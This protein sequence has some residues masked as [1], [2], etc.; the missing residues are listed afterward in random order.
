MRFG[1]KAKVEVM[2][3]N[4]GELV[5]LVQKAQ[6][7]VD[8]RRIGDTV[9]LFETSPRNLPIL[10]DILA[11]KCY[12]YKVYQ[13]RSVNL[14]CLCGFLVGIIVMLTAVI[15]LSQFCWG[16]KV[17]TK[18]DEITQK[19]TAFLD[20]QPCVSNSWRNI[21]C[22]SLETA[23]LEAVPEVGLVSVSRNGVFLVVNT[24]ESVQ[25]NE[26]KKQNLT[27][28]LLADRDGIVSRIFVANG[29]PLVNVGDTVSL[30]QMLVAPYLTDSA[31]N[32]T[33]VEVRADVYLYVWESS[34]VEFCE[35]SVEYVRT[36]EVLSTT[37]TQFL[38][39]TLSAEDK[40][41][42]FEHYETQVIR[43]SVS[44]VLPLF[45]ETTYYYKTEPVEVEKN[46]EAEREAL[47][48]EAKQKLLLHI[49]ESQ[50]LGEKYSVGQVGDKFYI[51][52]YAKCEYKVG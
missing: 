18:N 8:F 1:K 42:P 28:G 41:I 26:V 14:W 32:Q 44:G 39:A 40:T 48:Y 5:A 20:S 3:V 27:A 45:V 29:T 37:K 47:F 22:D 30:G 31:G 19:I 43:H 38:G 15:L 21:D 17:V 25:P 16:L 13:P 6:I 4:F 34:G 10:F 46:F 7:S 36:G 24:L 33:P 9:M 35:K 52:Y 51:N 49:D 12:T 11:K 50:I 2:G 23:I